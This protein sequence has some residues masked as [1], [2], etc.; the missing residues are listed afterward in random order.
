MNSTGWWVASV[1]T[2]IIALL[3]GLGW[4]IVWATVRP[5]SGDPTWKR[6]VARVLLPVLLVVAF[7]ATAYGV[8]H[9]FDPVPR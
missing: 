4:S 6:P 1:L 7:L 8:S 5:M 9:M 3:W 2:G